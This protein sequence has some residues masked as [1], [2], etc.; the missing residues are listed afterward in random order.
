[1]ERHCLSRRMLS[2]VDSEQTI[3][4]VLKWQN[5]VTRMNPGQ[6]FEVQLRAR[7]EA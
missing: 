2:A 6:N 5:Q 7:E 3:V 1:M 4:T